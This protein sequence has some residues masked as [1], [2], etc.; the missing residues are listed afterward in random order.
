MQRMITQEYPRIHKN[1][2]Y[3]CVQVTLKSHGH[4]TKKDSEEWSLQL[5]FQYKQ[6]YVAAI[7]V[8]T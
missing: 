4:K 1:T 2:L 7:W 6:F 5:V 8:G 3:S